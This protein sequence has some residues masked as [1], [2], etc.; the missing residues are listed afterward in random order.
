MKNNNK[1]KTLKLIT[2]Y[3]QMTHDQIQRV[4]D[5]CDTHNI[6]YVPLKTVNKILFNTN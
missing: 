5:L 1:N 3:E 4:L 6:A 2:D